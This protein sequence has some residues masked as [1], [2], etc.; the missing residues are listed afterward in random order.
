MADNRTWRLQNTLERL[1]TVQP[2][3]NFLRNCTAFC[4]A[5]LPP[6]SRW[7]GRFFFGVDSA[8]RL[9][10]EKPAMI[11]DPFICLVGEVSAY[12]E[13]FS[14]PKTRENSWRRFGKVLTRTRH[15]NHETP[16]PKPL[17]MGSTYTSTC[18]DLFLELVRTN[19]TDTWLWFLWF[20]VRTK[21]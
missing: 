19:H 18:S 8:A 5:S 16:G 2:C 20:L 14:F 15:A 7:G 10:R 1:K 21:M 6:T 12:P 11:N 13:R 4:A 3:S 17:H 9:L